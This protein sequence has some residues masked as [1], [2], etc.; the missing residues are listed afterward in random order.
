MKIVLPL[1]GKG[2]RLLPHTE[3]TPKPLMFLAGKTILDYLL[4]DLIPLQPTEFV[5]ITGYLKDQIETHIRKNYANLPARFIEQHNPQGLGHAVYQARDAFAKDEDMLVVLGDQTFT[6]DWKKM[7][8]PDSNRISIMNV[9]NPSSFGVVLTD[10]EGFVLEME[11]K[12][13]FPKSNTIITGTYYFQSAQEVFAALAHQITHNIRTR[14]EIQITD[15]MKL[16]MEQ[17]SAF[18]TLKITDWND[19]GNHEDLIQ[20]NKT[21]LKKNGSHILR[22]YPASV[23]IFEPVW[24]DES[25]ILENVSIGPNASIGAGCSLKDSIISDTI[26][27]RNVRIEDC[28]LSE[29]YITQNISGVA[30]KDLYA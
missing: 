29:C 2:T 12:P 15:T 16:M 20:A 6:I 26:V 7:L 8:S 10:S 19:C 1:A 5:F 30:D 3:I 28:Q 22:S 21:L 13:K 17:G 18:N 24:I 11:E 27:S 9:E 23:R 4:E 25:A 14:N